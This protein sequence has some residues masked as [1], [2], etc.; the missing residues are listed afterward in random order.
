MLDK[1][2]GLRCD[3]VTKYYTVGDE[4]YWKF[5]RQYILHRR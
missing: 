4:D 1:Q 3:I 5:S 2:I